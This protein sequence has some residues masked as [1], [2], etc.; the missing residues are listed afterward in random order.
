MATLES[1]RSYRDAFLRGDNLDSGLKRVLDESGDP[2]WVEETLRNFQQVFFP[3][4]IGDYYAFANLVDFSLNFH[5]YIQEN[6]RRI[7]KAISLKEWNLG[8][9]LTKEEENEEVIQ[10]HISKDFR[11]YFLLEYPECCRIDEEQLKKME[12]RGYCCGE[13]LDYLLLCAEIIDPQRRKYREI[14][15]KNNE[16]P[17]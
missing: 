12:E 16:L 15:K 7:R 13:A 14:I 5:K 1:V 6:I 4:N 8:R 3:N 11:L 2:Y 17:Q 10:N 9:K